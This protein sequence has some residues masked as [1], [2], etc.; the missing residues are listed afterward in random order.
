MFTYPIILV[1]CTN[2]YFAVTSLKNK[3][4]NLYLFILDVL[5]TWIMGKNLTGATR[6][7][8]SLKF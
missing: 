6:F 4:N 8:Y 1:G 2:N 5:G 3:D 7:E